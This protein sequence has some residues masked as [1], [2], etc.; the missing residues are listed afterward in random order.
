M[1]VKKNYSNS[2]NKEL[3]EIELNLIENDYFLK[4]KRL[5]KIHF[6]RCLRKFKLKK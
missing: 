3:K 2:V 6:Y 1:L 4:R 5:K